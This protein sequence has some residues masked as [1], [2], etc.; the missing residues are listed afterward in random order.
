[1]NIR[2]FYVVFS[3][4]VLLSCMIIPAIAL[5]EQRT[6]KKDDR[7]KRNLEFQTGNH[8]INP[9]T[10]R[11][12]RR[13]ST[14]LQNPAQYY[15]HPYRKGRPQSYPIPPYAVQMEPLFHYSQRDP[16]YDTNILSLD[17][18]NGDPLTENNHINHEEAERRGFI[19]YK[20]KI[21]EKPV[22][23]KEPEPIIEIII[24]ESNVSLPAPPPPP[25]PP[26]KKKEQV[27][28]F[29]VK[30][31]K[32]PDGEYGKDSIIYDKP[33]PAISPKLPEDD[34]PEE[35]E[36][37]YN[38]HPETATL[39]PPP[40]TTLRTVIRPDSETY[41]SPSGIKVTFGKEGFDYEKRSSKP[42]EFVPPSEQQPQGRQLNPQQQPTGRQLN[43][44]SNTYFKPPLSANQNFHNTAGIRSDVRPRQPYRPVSFPSPQTNYKP[45]ARPTPSQKPNAPLQKFSQ[46]TS[47]VPQH[48]SHA[49]SHPP[50]TGFQNLAPAP[51]VRQPVPYTPFENYRPHQDFPQSNHINQYR[52]QQIPFRPETHF[53]NQQLPHVQQ[54]SKFAQSINHKQ[55]QFSRPKDI[56]GQQPQFQFP[57]SQEITGPSYQQ[58]FT[59]P[60]PTQQA[61]PHFERPNQNIPQ[62]Y[63][64]L[65]AEQPFQNPQQILPSFNSVQ[66]NQQPKFQP[67]G[68][69]PLAQPP[70][71]FY[72]QNNF[73][74]QSPQLQ[75][76]P[77][78]HHSAQ[79]QQEHSQHT[80]NFIPPG[81]EL[82]QSLP[83]YETHISSVEP[84][85]NRPT[86]NLSPQQYQ[87]KTLEQFNSREQNSKEILTRQQSVQNDI[88]EQQRKYL[89]EQQKQQER[90]QEQLR[91]FYLQNDGGRQN[92]K[93]VIITNSNPSN[94]YHFS[95]TST[96]TPK[97]HQYQQFTQ[98]ASTTTTEASTPSTTTKDPKILEAQLPDE[99][100][101]ELREQLLSSG[102]LN[103]ADISILDYDKVGDIPLSALP[104][105]QL[106]NFFNAGGAQQIAGK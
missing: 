26:K 25:P 103:N 77:Q 76:S 57:R 80:Q 36:A 52:Q 79:I 105:D 37:P 92:N 28:V 85:V 102:I 83:K 3:F 41:H 60:R 49:I 4:Q 18:H 23:I 69:L 15:P 68:P 59:Q 61:R 11:L 88:L 101:A 14:S 74:Q 22:Y 75:Q 71:N 24:K 62:H 12:E 67:K 95:Q 91:Q 73:N 1:M 51:S 56:P 42:D 5:D 31:K 93:E 17:N 47:A 20:T 87:E 64:N 99:V 46:S 58:Q 39:P 84:P 6:K 29:F 66:F 54:D 90:E 65:P 81:G 9:S 10:Y 94:A 63:T 34:E 86:Q 104:P 50:P 21:I 32:N 82:I 78:F 98:S 33:I 38:Y 40:S 35:E 89:S 97:D 13:I 44:F 19:R 45:F 106:A 16:L 7:G 8:Y 55:P 27:Q 70:R 72:Q 96:T 30:Y 100:P 48:Y 2:Y 43:P 53:S